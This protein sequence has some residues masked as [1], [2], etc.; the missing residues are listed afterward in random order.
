MDVHVG[1]VG[2]RDL[3]GEIYRQLRSAIL[4][5]RLRG[6][7][8]LPPSREMAGRLSVSRTTVGVAY[9]RLISE[10]F[11]IARTG[12]GTF[13]S[14]QV[15]LT[16]VSRRRGAPGALRARRIWDDVVPLGHWRD[17]AF[18]F[19]P[20]IPDASLF[21]YETWRALIARQLRPLAVGRGGY[22]DPA[23]HDGLREA[24]SRHLGT[25]RGVRSVADDVIVTTGTQQA[26][27]LVARVLLDPGDRVAVEDPGYSP[28]RRLFQTLGL[29]VTGVPVDAEGL[30]VDAI[31]ANTKLVYVSPSHQFP[32]GTSMSLRRRMALLAWAREHDAAIVEDDYDSEFRYGGRPIE[33]VQMLDTS[34]RVIYVG[35]FSK[36]TLATLRLGFVIVPPSLRAATRA[37][38]F[39]TDWHTAL[40]TQA[41]MAGF[42]E[43]GLFARHVRRM[44]SVY[45]ARHERMVQV[46][47]RDFADELRI[48]PSSIGLHL[49][50]V[51]R[52]ATVDE[53]L[54]VIR[55]A[56][57]VGVECH[58]LSMYAAG[59]SPRAGLV[60]GYGA[61]AETEIEEGLARLRG[62]FDRVSGASARSAA[63]A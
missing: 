13:V 1:L 11:A 15:A 40:P 21:P 9:D 19:R 6:G 54:D 20:G 35:S 60:L 24:I 30:V 56:A 46:I 37:A 2:R 55:R 47:A 50:V 36:T 61:I 45:R 52:S 29:T 41:A 42:I 14:R 4:D 48:V 8:R 44:R 12:S 25:A 16:P 3:A 27:D 51:A 7:E 31:P 17:V 10:G 63:T 43:S 58:P 18:D 28:P 57:A 23:G 33:P 22:G 49:A 59:D 62:S 32:L 5:G 39:V 53:I 34:G 26:V 38:K